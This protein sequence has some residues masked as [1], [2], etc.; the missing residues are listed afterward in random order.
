MKRKAIA[1][2]SGG[3]DSLLAARIVKDQ[4]VEVQGIAF[5][6]AAASTDINK[7]KA[8]IEAAAEGAGIPVKVIDIS[9]EFLDIINSP[10]HGYGSN[11]NPCID[12]KIFMMRKAKEMMEEEG[13]G[14]IVTGE[15]L[16]ERPMSQNRRSLDLIQE[17]SSLGNLLLRP[18]SAKL[19]EPTLPEEEGMVDR[20]KLLEIRGRSRKP[21]LA[22]A[23]QLGIKKFSAPGTSCLLTD[24]EFSRKVKDLMRHGELDLKALALVKSGR[25]F[26]ATS[27]AQIVVGRDEKENGNLLS[28]KEEK[29]VIVRLNDVLP[30]PYALVRGSKITDE[31]IQEAA[32]L[33][34]SHSKSREDETVDIQFWTDDK[35]IKDMTASPLTKQ[36]VEKLKV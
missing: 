30:G 7:T 8:N 5:V 35:E 13:A 18:L 29:D 36:E 31:D 24:P 4:G 2:V 6:M 33:V 19:L 34:I 15:V 22:L 10:E 27:G 1:L 9:E 32:A 23:E 28:L 3:I 21:Q 25:Y 17:K 20:E 26:R 12:C 11:I 14:F 16:G